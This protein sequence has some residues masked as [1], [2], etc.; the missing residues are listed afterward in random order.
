MFLY[1][2]DLHNPKSRSTFPQIVSEG[3]LDAKEIKCQ[4]K[5]GN[6][7]KTVTHPQTQLK[8]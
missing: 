3:A 8:T 4:L 7:E 1:H 5:N 6:L 2:P